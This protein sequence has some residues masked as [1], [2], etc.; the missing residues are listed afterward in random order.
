[1]KPQIEHRKLPCLIGVSSVVVMVGGVCAYVFSASRK[2]AHVPLTTVRSL[3]PFLEENS[4]DEHRACTPYVAC[5]CK[6]R[7]RRAIHFLK[8]LTR[9]RPHRKPDSQGL[10]IVCETSNSVPS[11]SIPQYLTC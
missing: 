1:M 8:L 7:R 9:G 3:R 2:I 6:T 5:V 11:S 10:P 4:L